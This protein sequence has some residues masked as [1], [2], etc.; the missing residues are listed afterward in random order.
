MMP[1]Y[2]LLVQQLESRL[3]VDANYCIVKFSVIPENGSVVQVL[4]AFPVS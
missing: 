2:V 1:I 3:V 4:K